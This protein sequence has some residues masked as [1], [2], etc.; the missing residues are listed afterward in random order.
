M[1]EVKVV[2]EEQGIL[3]ALEF[4]DLPFVPKRAFYVCKVPRGV[5]RGGHA[6]Y[7][8]EQFLVCVK[9]VI[10]VRLYNGIDI[11]VSTLL[12]GDSI[13]VGRMV[14]DSQVFLTGDDILLA[15][16]STQYDPNDYIRDIEEFRKAVR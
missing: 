5:E 12:P 7:T 8:T 1:S 3:A 9:G 14:W 10:E 13:F 11:K 2:I 4:K 6:H 16:C 15:I